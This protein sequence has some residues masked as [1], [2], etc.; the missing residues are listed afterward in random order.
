M[1][2]LRRDPDPSA[3]LTRKRQFPDE[4]QRIVQWSRLIV[5]SEPNC[6]AGNTG[7]PPFPI[8]TMLQKTLHA[9]VIRTPPPFATDQHRCR[10]T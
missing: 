2:Q 8:A 1:K 4:I 3:K 6:S 9:R 10:Q 5:L 7:R